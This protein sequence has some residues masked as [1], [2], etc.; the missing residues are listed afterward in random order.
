MYLLNLR[1]RSKGV[2]GSLYL[3]STMYLLNP[4]VSHER[5]QKG[6]LYL[7][8]TMYLLNP[9]W[10]V[11]N[12]LSFVNLHSTMYLLNRTSEAVSAIVAPHLHSTMYLL[13]PLSIPV[14]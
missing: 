9:C 11:I 6:G 14:K 4:E 13:N 3:H 12:T 1:P 2:A 7:H 10:P 5:R 8:S